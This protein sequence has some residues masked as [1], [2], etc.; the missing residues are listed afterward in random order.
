MH[1]EFELEVEIIELYIKNKQKRIK[2][3]KIY[4]GEK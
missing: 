3:N 2:W 4:M 1:C